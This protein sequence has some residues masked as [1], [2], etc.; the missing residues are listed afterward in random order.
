MEQLG[1]RFKFKNDWKVLFQRDVWFLWQDPIYMGK[2]ILRR[3][4]IINI[5]R[6][7]FFQV[8]IKMVSLIFIPI[9]RLAEKFWY[10]KTEGGQF[11][12]IARELIKYKPNIHFYRMGVDKAE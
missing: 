6:W 3:F 12:V 8:I 1:V 4:T 7:Y 9:I 11:K 2:V 5:L 10:T